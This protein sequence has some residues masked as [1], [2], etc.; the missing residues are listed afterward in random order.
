MK[1]WLQGN[2]MEICSIIGGSKTVIAERYIRS[3]NNKIYKHVT[4]VSKNVCID[5]LDDIIHKYNNAYL[6]TITINPIDV[7]ISKYI[8]FHVANNDKDP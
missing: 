1:S 2:N 3:L 5:K 8:D 4:T 6:R 7:K